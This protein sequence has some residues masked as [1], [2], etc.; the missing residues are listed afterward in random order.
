MKTYQKL[1][2]PSKYPYECL[3]RPINIVVFLFFPR[4]NCAKRAM[5]SSLS[6]L[7]HHKYS[8]HLFSSG[9][10]RNCFLSFGIQNKMKVRQFLI[11]L[12]EKGEKLPAVFTRRF[13][14]ICKAAAP[15]NGIM[16]RLKSV[17][18]W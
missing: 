9:V 4:R 7:M 17:T 5:S 16:S 3:L 18:M 11:S 8:R 12:K 2:K 10:T 14:A 6:R 1:S 13:T 15:S